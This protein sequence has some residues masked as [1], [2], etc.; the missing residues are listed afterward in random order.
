MEKKTKEH[1]PNL[2]KK[3]ERRINKKTN[4]A[5]GYPV[6][7]LSPHGAP[8]IAQRGKATQFKK[9]VS[10]NPAGRP[11]GSK[12]K[13]KDTGAT[14]AEAFADLNDRLMSNGEML[15]S[16]AEKALRENTMTGLKLALECV[17][18]AN[19]YIEPTMDAKEISSQTPVEDLSQKEIK[20]RLLRIVNE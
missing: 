14:V 6:Y 10:G 15:A 7:N 4:E 16:I 3:L 1:I 13:N 12:N 9:G 8:D 11:K 5:I 20:D 19:K 18:E 17:K 2:S